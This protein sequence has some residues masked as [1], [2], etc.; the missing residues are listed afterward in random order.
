[1][2]C[3]QCEQTAGGKG[4]T[5]IGVCGKTPETSDLQDLLIYA[6]QGISM[7]AYRA[8]KLGLSDRSIDRFVVEALFTTVTN[9]NFDPVRL[10]A[11]IA[12]AGQI[13]EQAK[14][15]YTEACGKKNVKPEHLVGPAQWQ[16]PGNRDEM[17][18]QAAT[19]CVANRLKAYGDDV[20]GLQELIESLDEL[21]EQDELEDIL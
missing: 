20:A 10:E 19:H 8:G 3:Y 15:L 12:K 2:F 5:K 6:T 1:M 13:I 4:C 14:A 16:V 18:K 9:V 7:Y 11:M 21:E 17:L